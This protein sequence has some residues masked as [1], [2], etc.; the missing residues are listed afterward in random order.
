V[1]ARGQPPS[2]ARHRGVRRAKFA[3]GQRSS[4]LRARGRAAACLCRRGS[5]SDPA[6]IKPRRAASSARPTGQGSSRQFRPAHAWMVCVH[7]AVES[8]FEAQ[9][10]TSSIVHA[11]VPGLVKSKR[12]HDPARSAATLRAYWARTVRS[13]SETTP[14]RASSS[15]W[16]LLMRTATAQELIA[17]TREAPHGQSMYLGTSPSFGHETDC[18]LLSSCVMREGRARATR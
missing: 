3:S 14:P 7:A 4:E 12:R 5:R 18:S 1:L 16:P 9:P 10:S 11:A 17:S 6:E 13:G 8:E 15:T 2:A